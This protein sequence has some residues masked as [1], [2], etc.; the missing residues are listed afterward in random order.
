MCKKTLRQYV[1]LEIKGSIWR[2]CQKLVIYIF[3]FCDNLFKLC[4]VFCLYVMYVLSTF[5]RKQKGF[6]YKVKWIT[7]TLKLAIS[8]LLRMQSLIIWFFVIFCRLINCTVCLLYRL[9]V[10]FNGSWK[11]EYGKSDPQFTTLVH[12]YQQ[13]I[14]TKFKSKSSESIMGIK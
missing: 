2:F 10:Q 14:F 6:L 4:D 13:T 3:F 12:L 7:K 8:E 11:L 9:T 5:L 1:A